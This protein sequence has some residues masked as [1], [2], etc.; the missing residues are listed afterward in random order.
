MK[1]TF[2]SDTHTKHNQLNLNGGDILI[3][4]GDFMNSG[5]VRSNVMSFL[6]WF[7]DQPYRHKIFIAG[8][9][10]RFFQEAPEEKERILDVFYGGLVTYLEDSGTKVNDVNVWGSPWQPEFFNW[11]Y[12]LPRQG[13]EL[14]EKWDMIPEN[15]DIL[16]T[17]G[18]PHGYLDKLPHIPE[19]LGCELLRER[20]DVVKPKIHVFGH[21]HYGHGYVTNGD[22]HFINAAVLNEQCIHEH[23]PINVEWNPETNELAFV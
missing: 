2:I 20:V 12:N 6:D 16:I 4:S 14:K 19:N 15:T 8:N 10:D 9:H 18:P 11:A 1:L 7:T 3:H 23:K 13:T 21:I 22:T 17:H 5:Y